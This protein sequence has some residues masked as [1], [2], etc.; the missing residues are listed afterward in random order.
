MHYDAQL[1]LESEGPVERFRDVQAEVLLLGGS[2]SP[3]YLKTTLDALSTV[4]PRARRVE[5]LRV[6][7]LAADNTGRPEQV[8]EELRRFF[9]RVL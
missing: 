1:V 2:R 9:F 3:R 4:L 7:H 5:F 8:A 6:G